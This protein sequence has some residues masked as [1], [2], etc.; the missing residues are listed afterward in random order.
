MLVGV[1]L[2]AT[3]ALAGALG[4]FTLGSAQ[5]QVPPKATRS[6]SPMTVLPGGT[7]TVTIALK[8]LEVTDGF[9]FANVKEKIPSGF[10]FTDANKTVDSDGYAG[11]TRL[12]STTSE[13]ITYEVT[14]SMTVGDHEFMGTMST[15]DPL[16]DAVNTYPV[17]GAKIVTVAADGT[18]TTDPTIEV[19]PTAT[20]KTTPGLQP[21][22]D[23]G[24]RC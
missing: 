23:A 22:S 20:T 10:S 24:S 4:I 5:A 15:D 7:V 18:G 9:A 2:F 19:E 13:T 16:T 14:A 11:F 21:E 17:D 6:F 8:N 1:A 3:L 12:P